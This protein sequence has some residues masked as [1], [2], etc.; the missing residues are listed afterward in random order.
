MHPGLVLRIPEADALLADLRA[1]FPD[2]AADDMPAHVTVIFPFKPW[3][4]VN[5][6]DLLTLKGLFGALRPISLRFETTGRFP[7]VLWLSPTPRAE[8]DRLTRAVVAAFPDYPPY[9]GAYD[10]PTPHLTLALG[11][12]S[13][14]DKAERAV[15]RRLVTPLRSDIDAVSAYA[16]TDDGW[17]EMECFPLGR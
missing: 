7:G 2:A 5:R 1:G 15:A 12:D 9:E 4:T 16:L 6:A 8:V 14:L 17:R 10:D 11:D 3:E 13:A